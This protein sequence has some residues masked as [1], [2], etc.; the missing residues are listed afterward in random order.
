[1]V[2][3]LVDYCALRSL[4]TQVLFTVQLQSVTEALRVYAVCLW[5]LGG[6][7]GPDSPKVVATTVSTLDASGSRVAAAAVNNDH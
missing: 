7:L 3:V 5:A 6:I 2:F 4:C 1:M